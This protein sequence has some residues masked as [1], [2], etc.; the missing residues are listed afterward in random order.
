MPYNRQQNIEL[1]KEY[2]SWR[3]SFDSCN[4][5]RSL[6][7]TE[8]SRI[9][10]SVRFQVLK[11]DFASPSS[12]FRTDYSTA[13]QKSHPTIDCVLVQY[14]V[15]FFCMVGIDQRWSET[16]VNIKF[17]FDDETHCNGARSMLIYEW[18]L[19]SS[20]SAVQL[21]ESTEICSAWL[22]GP[23]IAFDE[24]RFRFSSGSVQISCPVDH[25]SERETSAQRTIRHH[26]ASS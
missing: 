25:L 18:T 12:G 20:A 23:W 24:S 10:R 4:S 15:V 16:F 21:A 2:I 26:F 13:P 5:F 11:H 9:D 8:Y 14:T 6:R 1:T 3:D 22:H 7:Q 17:R 19:Y